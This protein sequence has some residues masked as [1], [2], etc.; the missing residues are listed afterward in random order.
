MK[1]F[2]LLSLMCIPVYM[3]ARVMIDTI[4]AVVYTLEGT[5]I[6]V[7]S[8]VMRPS[9]QGQ[10]RPLE[11]IVFESLVYLDAEKHKVVPDDDAVDRYLASIMQ[12]NDMNQQQLEAVFMEGGRTL[13]EGREELKRMQTFNTMIDFKIR[14]NLLVPRKEVEAYYN[15]HPEVEPARFTLQRA[16]VPFDDSLAPADQKTQL[17]MQMKKGILPELSAEFTIEASD[18]AEDKQFILKL[19]VGQISLPRESQEG[20]ELYRLIAK[21]E[22]HVR[23]L[24]DRYREISSLLMQPRYIEMM[25][26]YRKQLYDNAAIVYLD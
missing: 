22:E 16:F 9:L 5:Q 1:K 14:G 21:T 6:I 26:E 4:D 15:E 13:Q 7:R 24:E 19:D 18:I 11:A 10:Q 3:Y 20:F 8:D 23:S 12:E 25:Q 17:V 2:F